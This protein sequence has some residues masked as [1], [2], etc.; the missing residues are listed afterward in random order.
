M[1]GRGGQSSGLDDYIDSLTT[2][3]P[4]QNVPR[5][6]E[7]M[8]VGP[9]GSR[10]PTGYT[11]PDPGPNLVEQYLDSLTSRRPPEEGSSAD[12][13]FLLRALAAPE[14]PNSTAGED[15]YASQRWRMDTPIVG[16]VATSEAQAAYLYFL[17]KGYEM[18]YNRLDHFTGASGDP[19]YLTPEEI[20]KISGTKRVSDA[21]E[22][23]RLAAID[24]AVEKARQDPSLYGKPQA[25]NVGETENMR[26]LDNVDKDVPIQPWYIVQSN[27]FADDVQFSLG[28]FST[29]TTGVVVVTGPSADG[30]GIDYDI[31]YQHN[32][33]DRYNFDE[34]RVDF[35]NGLGDAVPAAVNNDMEQLHNRG[36]AQNFDQSGSTSV[37]VEHGTKPAHRASG[38][39]ISGPGSS[40][41]DKI[42]AWLS[43]GEFVMNARTTSV[44]RPFLQALNADPQFLQKMLA[45]QS[46]QGRRSSGNAYAPPTAPGQPATVNISMSSNE[47]IISRLKVLAIQWELSR[48]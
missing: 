48:S 35:G 8:M 5:T 27:G 1:G 31:I 12:L 6:F 20:A 2:T 18:S 32:Y 19:Y 17:S 38:G 42:P 43:D 16:E 47:D 46:D 9:D 22:V 23:Q 15:P 45:S 7:E 44:N 30:S 4:S 36:Y 24:A 11:S 25:I 40:I 26:S 37:N 14:S 34:K 39:E 13:V 29:N 28:N 21:N 3:Q 10:A 41:G 33:Y